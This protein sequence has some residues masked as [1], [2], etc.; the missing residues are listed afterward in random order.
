M[1]KTFTLIAIIV[2]FYS[3]KSYS[4]SDSLNPFTEKEIL[5]LS[6]V[7]YE[8]EKRDSA[9]SADEPNG[10]GLK[11]ATTISD[12]GLLIDLNNDS[13]HEY[14]GA[15]VIK[16][17]NYIFELE[18]RDSIKN[19]NALA[20]KERIAN[21]VTTAGENPNI[22]Y[23]VQIG[24]YRRNP[25]ISGIREFHKLQKNDGIKKYLSG[26]FKTKEEAEN[27]KAELTRQGIKDL[28]IVVLEEGK[29]IN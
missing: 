28:Y 1:K 26:E 8:L 21:P 15:E 19:A 24:A 27:R 11:D 5:K 23:S 17:S 10:F 20:E 4:L 3:A 2:I 16:L 7:I 12:A 6:N 22:S 14:T 25:T 29:P 9:A 13:V 18:R